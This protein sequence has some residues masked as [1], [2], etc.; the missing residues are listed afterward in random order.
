MSKFRAFFRKNYFDKDLPFD[1]RMFMI[2][3]FLALFMSLL[4]ATTN[5]ILGKGLFGIIVQWVFNVIFIMVLLMPIRV[6]QAMSKPL[7]LI[8]AFFYVPLLSFY[9]AGYDGTAGLIAVVAVFLIAIL[10][11][12]TARRWLVTANILLWAAV[13]VLQ[14]VF[15]QLVVPHGSGQAK[16]IDY[17]VAMIISYA[18]TAIL[19]IHFS[20]SYRHEQKRIQT[21]AEDLERSNIQLAEL[22][23]RDP[24]TGAYN[25]RFL[26]ESLEGKLI[27]R[28]KSK[29]SLYI[30]MMDLDDFKLLND[31]YGHS[32]GDEVLEE[33]V[34]HVQS[35]LR[36]EDVFA[37]Y[38]GEEFVAVLNT[39]DMETAKGVAERIRAAVENIK[40]S[41]ETVVCT[42]SI[43]LAKAHEDDQFEDFV[44]RADAA[45]YRAKQTGKN[46]VCVDGETD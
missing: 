46:R 5:T 4:S 45:L 8:S 26:T 29:E 2:F 25:R 16:F 44:N 3:F 14:F 31:T 40:F 24:L 36:K 28:R 39:T 10:Y 33:V 37:R 35:I 20:N 41:I 23:T 42:I 30:L 17:M 32:F 1:Y 15:P 19:G 21:L 11:E 12:G 27:A 9:T 6:R 34:K 43:G 18:G 22:T 7:L 13:C 38:G